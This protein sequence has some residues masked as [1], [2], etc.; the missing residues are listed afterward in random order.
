MVL[1]KKKYEPLITNPRVK[2]GVFITRKECKM[3]YEMKKEKCPYCDPYD[4]AAHFEARIEKMLFLLT[5]PFYK[6][7]SFIRENFS[8]A[9]SLISETVTRWIV[10]FALGCGILKEIDIISNDEQINS[11]SLV[12]AHAA[13]E[14]GMVMKSLRLF[15]KREMGIFSI[16]INDRKIF[17]ETMP[18][19]KVGYVPLLDFDDKLILKEILRK[20][21]FP[22][23][24]G[25]AFQGVSKALQYGERLGFPLMVKPRSGSLSKHITGDIKDEASLMAAIRVTRMLSYEFMVERFIPGQVYR[26]SVINND[27]LACCLREPPNVIGDGIHTIKE[28][29]EIKNNNPLRGDV[30]QKNFT[31]HKI[32]LTEETGLLMSRKGLTFQSIP[33]KGEK[34]YLH[35]KVILACGADIKDVTGMLHPDNV[36]MFLMLSKLL[37]TSIVGIDF[38]CQDISK[39]YKEQACAILEANSLP[40][41]DMHHFPVFGQPRDLAGYIMDSFLVG[42][43]NPANSV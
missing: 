8:G 4:N 23:A 30:Q 2:P 3:I 24:E 42:T 17:F 40:Y 33:P 10:K 21:G 38:I 29:V 13:Q 31:L 43:Q 16:T 14:R 32:R 28:L 9:L 37:K 39:S 6:I 35:N 25:E 12:I 22:Y 20:N 1:V 41:I 18:P 11:R 26:I 15:G 5:R 34:N 36:H 19:I 27:F 7:E